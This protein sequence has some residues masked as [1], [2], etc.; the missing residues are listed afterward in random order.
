[1]KKNI[2]KKI[3]AICSSLVITTACAMNVSAYSGT[4]VGSKTTTQ[5][6]DMGYQTR[7]NLVVYSHEINGTTAVTSGY[8]CSTYIRTWGSYKV[9]NIVKVQVLVEDCGTGSI[10]AQYVNSGRTYTGGASYHFISSE[11]DT[12]TKIRIGNFPKTYAL[13]VSADFY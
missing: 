3:L 7:S 4:Y 13:G 12:N 5:T 9:G 6:T 8:P 10:N 11:D 1:M 2:A